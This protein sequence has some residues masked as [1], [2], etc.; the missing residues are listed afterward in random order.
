LRYSGGLIPEIQ[1]LSNHAKVYMTTTC[2]QN[3]YGYDDSSHHN[4]ART[5]YFLEYGLINHFGSNTSTTMDACFD[6]ALA[7][8]PH[9][10]GD[11]PQE[12]DGNTSSSFTL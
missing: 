2:T 12:Y 8:Y 6:Y 11:T 9:G 10:G 4:G 7:A 5:Y 1:A 3:G